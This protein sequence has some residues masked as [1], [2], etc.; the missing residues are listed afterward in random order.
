MWHEPIRHGVSWKSNKRRHGMQSLRQCRRTLHGFTLIELLVVISIIA[1][2]IGIL[3]P[4]LAAARDAARL[5][6]SSS[7]QRQIAIA[8][9]AWMAE[10]NYRLL[11]PPSGIRTYSFAVTG[12]G[13]ESV[14]VNWPANY[15]FGATTAFKVMLPLVLADYGL[16]AEGAVYS[17]GDA[18]ESGTAFEFHQWAM[19]IGFGGWTAPTNGGAYANYLNARISYEVPTELQ[20]AGK[21]GVSLES[22]AEPSRKA[23]VYEQASPD[24]SRYPIATNEGYPFRQSPYKSN[25]SA[26]TDLASG[27]SGHAAFLD[28]HVELY[29]VER[30]SGVQSLGG[31]NYYVPGFGLSWS[32]TGTSSYLTQPD[33]LPR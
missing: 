18:Y 33:V 15:V 25:F 28:G 24:L 3:L 7:N 29:D 16:N 32:G 12:G 23:I 30:A 17:P 4:A 5:T 22:I 11:S 1:L 19:T 8:G 20:E 2:L 31:V 13:M 26:R 9:N 10:S 21:N 14:T 6:K 27:T